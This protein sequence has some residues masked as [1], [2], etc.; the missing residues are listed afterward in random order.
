MTWRPPIVGIVGAGQLARM[1]IQAAIPLDIRIVLLAADANDGAAQ[2]APNVIVGSP[3]DLGALKD[4]AQRSDVITFDHELVN[5][6]ALARLEAAGF[7]S[8]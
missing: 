3:N 7:T 4:L 5:P 1:T 8:S 2:I 6:A